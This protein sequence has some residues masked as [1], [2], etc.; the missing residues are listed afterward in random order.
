MVEFVPQVRVLKE[1]PTVF[2]RKHQVQVDLSQ[3][4]RHEWTRDARPEEETVMFMPHRR[5]CKLGTDFYPRHEGSTRIVHQRNHPE[6]V[7]LPKPRV[8]P[9]HPG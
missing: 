6:G 7:G 3:R 8:A 4:L 2:G 1:W 9:A 5:L